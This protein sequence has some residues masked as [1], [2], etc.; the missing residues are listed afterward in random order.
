MKLNIG[1]RETISKGFL[2]VDR[3]EIILPNGKR[4]FREVLQKPNGIAILPISSTGEVYLTKQPRAG[5]GFLES[6]EIPAGLI[7]E[8][9]L[10]EVSA[11]RELSEETGCILTNPLIPLEKF[12]P[13]PSCCTNITYLFLALNVKKVG[14]HLNM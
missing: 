2:N 4:I 9:E 14:E 12:V 10:P 3:I 6:I 13:D 5:V 8:D 1:S 7:N 11:E